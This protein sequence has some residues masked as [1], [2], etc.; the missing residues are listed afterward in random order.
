MEIL[1]LKLSVTEV[2]VNRL[3]AEHLPK[4]V[5]VKKLAV[6]LTTA[7]VRVQGEY[8]TVFMNVGFDTVWSLAVAGGLL[9][10]RL[11]DLKVSGF[12]ATMLRGL[13]FKELKHSVPSEPGLSVVDETI[14]IDL[15]QFLNAKGLPL[16]I[17][18]QDVIC[19]QG[20]LVVTAGPQ[21]PIV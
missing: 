12:P 11:A 7:G 9:E 2:D 20:N 10:V 14:Q 1:V 13:I 17:T 16:K 4:D 3:L 8:P 18:L 21:T 5:P 6:Q 15:Q 19:G